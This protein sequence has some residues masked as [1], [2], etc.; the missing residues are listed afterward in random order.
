[1][2]HSTNLRF[3]LIFDLAT[4]SA[5]TTLSQRISSALP[6]PS[7][8]VHGHGSIPHVT[9]LHIKIDETERDKVAQ[10]FQS[11]EMKGITC[12]LGF[13]GFKI[14]Q[15]WAP[16][17]RMIGVSIGV[18][19]TSQLLKLQS[20]LAKMITGYPVGNSLG[21]DY[22]PHVTLGRYAVQETTPALPYDGIVMASGL[23]GRLVLGL[24]DNI[25]QLTEIIA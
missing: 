19:P 22:R 1:M 10:A 7:D 2:N 3:A 14:A 8:Y 18:Q 23:T 13:T 4:T 5:I 11:S 17:D 21:D 20:D 12:Q 25:G 24:S 15:G 9:V 6:K 16:E